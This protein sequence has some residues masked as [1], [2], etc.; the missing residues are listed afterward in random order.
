MFQLVEEMVSVT[1]I[2]LLNLTVKHPIL[3]SFV[4]CLCLAILF[5]NVEGHFHAP[6]PKGC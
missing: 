3:G 2:L 6:I 4:T 5:P 1:A